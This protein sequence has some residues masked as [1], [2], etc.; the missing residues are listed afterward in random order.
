MV[1]GS[2]LLNFLVFFLVSGRK[3]NGGSS[4]G[5]RK[6]RFIRPEKKTASPGKGMVSRHKCAICGRTELS[7]PELSF[8]FCSKCAGNY[9]YCQEHLFTHKH[10]G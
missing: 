4:P 1:I 2:S 5:F 6:I 3:L 7:N 8:R 10:I 9:E